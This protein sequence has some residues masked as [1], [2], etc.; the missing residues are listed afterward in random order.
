LLAFIKQGNSKQPTSTVGDNQQKYKTALKELIELISQ[1]LKE[2]ERRS[3]H[4]GV[5][6]SLDFHPPA[7]KPNRNAMPSLKKQAS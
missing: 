6:E 1:P 7:A 5:P 3:Y 4:H 2:D